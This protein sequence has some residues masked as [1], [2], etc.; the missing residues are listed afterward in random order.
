M[1]TIDKIKQQIE[2]NAILLY[3]KGSPKL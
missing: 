1:E 3:M 2:E